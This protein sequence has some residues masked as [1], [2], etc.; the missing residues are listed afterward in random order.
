MY[1]SFYGLKQA[2]FSI[3]PDPH[4]LYMSERHREALA[5]LLYGVGGGGGFV[6]L[7]G[8]IGAGKTTVCRCFLEQVPANCNVAYIFNPKLSVPELLK[9]VCDEFGVAVGAGATSVKDYLDP[10]NAYLLAQHSAGRN[11]VLI[12]D[13]A[14]NLTAEV[15]EQL[16]LLTNLETS[17]RKLLQII[18]IGQ[19]E[20][21]EMLA[22]PELEQLAQRVIARFHLG[23]L[24]PAETAQYIAHR[25]FV[26]G[27][28]GASP[29]D[30]KALA[31]IHRITR[32]VP[33]RI[34]LL[35]DRA[36]LGGYANGQSRVNAKLVTQA[37]QEVFGDDHAD[38]GQGA[39]LGPIV[40]L[41][42]TG[43]LIGA[44]GTYL[45]APHGQPVPAAASAASGADVGA[46]AS[47]VAPSASAPPGLAAAASGLPASSSAPASAPVQAA[48]SPIAAASG[49]VAAA[50]LAAPPDKVLHVE[51]WPNPIR[52]EP[53]AWRQLADAWHLPALTGDPCEAAARAAQVYCY[54]VHLSAAKVQLLDRPGIVTLR[55]GQ[56]PLT[57][58]V[59]EGLNATQAT[60]RMGNVRRTVTL[61][62]LTDIWQGEFATYWRAPEGHTE[63]LRPGSA[64]RGVD[65]LAAALAKWRGVAA[66]PAG[67]ARLDAALT[68]QIVAFQ[69]AQGLVADGLAGPST[70]MQLNRIMGLDE[71]RLSS[72]SPSPVAPPAK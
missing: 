20:L 62:A 36:L 60:L 67:S 15:L 40:V 34:N 11:S 14:Q 22:R 53:N 54:R 30:A 16:R 2:P 24:S 39:R 26:A 8:E 6:L 57:Y 66:P 33:R 29:F 55:T 27:L 12:I 58:A 49:G 4:Y 5:H 21:R 59:L 56:G 70:L 37:A 71:P 65:W 72:A 45:W 50:A 41:A 44:V 43:A 10:L 28:A 18:L 69:N 3:A 35:C 68:A 9:T 63:L 38:D 48:P 32:G 52:D 7:S 19:P 61:S 23:A 42:L 13:E 47:A 31:S 64:G 51:A 1:L 25:L 17:E 46:A